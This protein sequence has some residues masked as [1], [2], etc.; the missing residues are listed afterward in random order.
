MEHLRGVTAAIDGEPA[1]T[2]AATRIALA[3]GMIPR[4]LPPGTKPLYHAAAVTVCGHVT[5]LFA[6]A[7]AMLAQCGFDEA[8]SRAA[9]QPLLKGTVANLAHGNP[10]EVA[11][12]PATR[13]DSATIRSH[14]EALEALDPHLAATYR[15]LTETARQLAADRS[16]SVSWLRKPL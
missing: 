4:A 9:L 15:R 5:A 10:A 12:G 3:L 2:E 1:G 16:E 14:L 11:T 13:G 7:Q 8:A 6:Q